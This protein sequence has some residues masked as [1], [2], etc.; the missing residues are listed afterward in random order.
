[1][2]LTSKQ[3]KQNSLN[4]KYAHPSNKSRK[5]CF[6][7]A[8]STNV[9]GSRIRKGAK[10]GQKTKTTKVP[11]LIILELEVFARRTCIKGAKKRERK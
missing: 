10:S 6:Y 11:F 2:I 5:L 4:R 3:M 7:E 8:P 1:M 9:S